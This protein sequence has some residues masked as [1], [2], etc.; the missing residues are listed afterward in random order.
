M[1]TATLAQGRALAASLPGYVRDDAPLDCGACITWHADHYRFPPLDPRF[2]EAW[3]MFLLLHDQQRLGME[4]VGIDYTA[5]PVVLDL[6][7]VDEP[8]ERRRLFHE[9]VALNHALQGHQGEQREERAR[10]REREQAAARLRG[11]RR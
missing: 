4:P 5:I 7:G 8:A 6:E 1:Q 11:G 10:T 2:Y 3:S 9:L